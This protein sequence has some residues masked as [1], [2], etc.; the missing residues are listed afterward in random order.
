MTSQSTASA[1]S[2]AGLR[3]SG[4]EGGE[5]DV[6]LMLGFLADAKRGIIR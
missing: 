1:S 4:V 6:E 2:V 5:A 3:G